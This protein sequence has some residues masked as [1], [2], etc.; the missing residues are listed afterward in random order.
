[1][2]EDVEFWSLDRVMEKVGLSR[3]EIYRRA[4]IGTF[5]ASRRYRDSTRCYWLSTEVRTWQK[6]EL[7]NEPFDV[8]GLI[9]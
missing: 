4:K 3:S 6:A 8:A 7:A 5:P 1:M 9:G 2:A